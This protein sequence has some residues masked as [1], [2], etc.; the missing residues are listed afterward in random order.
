MVL[1]R[2]FEGEDWSWNVNHGHV[3]FGPDTLHDLRSV[4]KSIASLLY[5]IALE[6][7]LVPPVEASVV[8]QFPEYP[9][10]VADPAR[11][12]ITIEHALNMTMGLEWDES[13]PYTSVANS[14]IAMEMAPDR[15]RFILDRPVVQPPGQSWI[16]SGGAV[17]LIG[18]LVTRGTGKSLAEFAGETLFGPLGITD[19]HWMS[20][21]D[22]VESAA[23]GLRLTAR[24]LLAIG[25]ML[26]NGGRHNGR[27][28]VPETWIN[29]VFTQSVRTP[30]GMGYSRLFYLTEAPVPAFGGPT[31]WIG[32]F[33]NGGQRLFLMP[34]ANLACVIFA[35][36]YNH[37]D[38]WI[39]P[40]RIWREIVLANLMKA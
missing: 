34:K 11:Q 1:E 3:A 40:T 5:G 7:G 6:R 23:S 27:Q 18:A 13:Q 30:D 25:E 37:P 10:L 9:D 2:Y 26:V 14:E 20:G 17:A 39:T 36:A 19:Y 21:A 38:N 4:T 28:I 35:G 33:G 15:F 31:P 24:G 22:G 32:C 8:A 29:A 12:G 16:Y